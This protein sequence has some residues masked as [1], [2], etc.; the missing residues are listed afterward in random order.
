MMM[1][2]SCNNDVLHITD[3]AETKYRAHTSNPNTAR[4]GA[5]IF[6]GLP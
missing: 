6:W 3:V 2:V 5:Y 4:F 1:M